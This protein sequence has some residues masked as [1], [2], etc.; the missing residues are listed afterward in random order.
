MGQVRQAVDLLGLPFHD[1]S[2]GS[3]LRKQGS[4]SHDQQP[5]SHHLH[6]VEKSETWGILI[7][8][9]CCPRMRSL[10]QQLKVV[11]G[12][13]LLEELDWGSPSLSSAEEKVLLYHRAEDMEQ[14]K[15][16]LEPDRWKSDMHMVAVRV[17]ALVRSVLACRGA[18]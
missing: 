11:E 9:S 10:T 6:L 18:V 12:Q 4:L 3:Q 5:C 16:V 1:Q 17:L 15:Q 8:G 14:W 13:G 2:L 7:L